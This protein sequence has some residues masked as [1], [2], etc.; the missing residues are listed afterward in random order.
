MTSIVKDFEGATAIINEINKTGNECVLISPYVQLWDR[1]R[2]ALSRAHKRNVAIKAYVRQPEQDKDKEKLKQIVAD[3]NQYGAKVYL[4]PNLHAKIYLFDESAIVSSMNL[5]DYSQQ[6]SIELSVL[7]DDSSMIADIRDFVRDY[8]EIKAIPAD[9]TLKSGKE[10]WKKGFCILCGKQMEYPPHGR[11]VCFECYK[12][13]QAEDEIST[14]EKSKSS[15]RSLKRQDEP[16]NEK[17]LLETLGE[18]L[19]TTLSRLG[20][21]EGFCIRCGTSIDNNPDR[22]LCNN[23]YIKWAEYQ[24]PNYTEKFCLA[25]GEKARTS[26]AKPYCY[27][28]FR[29]G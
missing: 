28:C 7:I 21:D 24:N 1:M 14:A 2:D 27:D 19:A 8:I 18:A 3:F 11:P 22:P 12:A 29:N 6:N 4:I 20:S 25:C 16:V 15:T 17:T 10:N 23:C 5:Y 26:Y 13:G 9:E